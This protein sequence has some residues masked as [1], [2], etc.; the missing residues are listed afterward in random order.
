MLIDA[1]TA[2]DPVQRQTIQQSQRGTGI[3]VIRKF[4]FHPSVLV[5]DNP[6]LVGQTGHPIDIVW[7]PFLDL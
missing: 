7:F 3:A 4:E 5:E 2:V 1:A 6:E